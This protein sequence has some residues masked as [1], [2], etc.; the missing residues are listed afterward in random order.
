M[1]YLASDPRLKDTNNLSRLSSMEAVREEAHKGKGVAARAGFEPTIRFPEHPSDSLFTPSRR[2]G[3]S[4]Y[5]SNCWQVEPVSALLNQVSYSKFRISKNRRWRL[6][7]EGSAV[8]D[9]QP[10]SSPAETDER[11]ANR[12]KCRRFSNRQKSRLGDRTGWLPQKDSNSQMSNS[13]PVSDAKTWKSGRK[14]GNG[15]RLVASTPK[16]RHRRIAA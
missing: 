9:Y 2:F 13:N 12:R 10:R 16:N 7:P 6:K 1:V 4:G 14:L 8:G 15:F 11:R 5:R 3:T